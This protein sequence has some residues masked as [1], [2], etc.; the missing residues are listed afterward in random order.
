M[1]K[2]K[3]IIIF[4]KKKADIYLSHYLISLVRQLGL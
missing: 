3:L 2:K 4:D 1:N